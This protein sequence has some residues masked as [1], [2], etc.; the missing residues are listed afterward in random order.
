[1]YDIAAS[2]AV[3]RRQRGNLKRRD[4]TLTSKKQKTIIMVI[5]YSSISALIGFPNIRQRVLAC[6][7][8]DNEPL[9]LSL[10]I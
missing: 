2:A 5:K 6:Q 3:R 7:M 10:N 8:V 4:A 1:M 9:L